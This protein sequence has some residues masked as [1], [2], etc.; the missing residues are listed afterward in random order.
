MN[1]NPDSWWLWMVRAAS[2]VSF[3]MI[4][5][6]FPPLTPALALLLYG[7]YVNLDG[8]ALIGMHITSRNRRGWLLS[9]G[10]LAWITGV[11]ILLSVSTEA[12]PLTY[13]LAT[14]TVMRG[15]AELIAG[16]THHRTWEGT[17]RLTGA[18]S[19]VVFGLALGAHERLS[20]SVLVLCFALHATFSS[21]CQF[22]VGLEQSGHARRRHRRQQGRP[23]RH[24]P[25]RGLLV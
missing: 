20:L 7:A 25:N 8:F 11:T 4:A 17:L 1:R 14:L 2:T 12:G 24:A 6:V 9:A 22:G 15:S 10:V 21:F 3:A 5:I 13:V 19:I 23:G 18:L 16:L